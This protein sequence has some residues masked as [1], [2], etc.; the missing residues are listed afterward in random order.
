[1]GVS[2]VTPRIMTQTSATDIT[3]AFE[4]DLTDLVATAFG[5]GAVVEGEWRVGFP[6]SGTPEWTVTI[7]KHEPADAPKYEPEFLSK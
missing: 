3:A 6:V 2:I 1:M 7:Q 5:R 4:H